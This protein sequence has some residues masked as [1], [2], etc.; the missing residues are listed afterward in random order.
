MYETF[1]DEPSFISN[2]QKGR[3]LRRKLYKKLKLKTSA[4]MS[5]ISLFQPSRGELRLFD[6]VKVKG[7][8][9]VQTS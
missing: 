3:N 1:A 5:R 9:Q 8:V 7:K 2:L 6:W 4:N